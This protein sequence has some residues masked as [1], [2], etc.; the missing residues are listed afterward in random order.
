[1]ILVHYIGGTYK[2]DTVQIML[3]QR[4]KFVNNDKGASSSASNVRFFQY[5]GF[6]WI[7]IDFLSRIQISI[8]SSNPG[9]VDDMSCSKMNTFFTMIQ[10]CFLDIPYSLSIKG[11]QEDGK[12]RN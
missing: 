7:R 8:G 2:L 4:L 10:R 3:L 5:S 11:R 9:L 6:A 1:M 12:D